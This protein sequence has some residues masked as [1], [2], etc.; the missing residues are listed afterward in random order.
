MRSKLARNTFRRSGYV[1]TEPV[2][3]TDYVIAPWWSPTAPIYFYINPSTGLDTNLGWGTTMAAAAASPLKTY[4]EFMLRL[5]PNGQGRSYKCGLAAG[6][7][8]KKDGIT[9]DDF[10]YKGF[11]G[12]KFAC[13]NGSNGV[14]DANDKVDQNGTSIGAFTVLAYAGNVVTVSGGLT[15]GTALVGKKIRWD[16]NVTAALRTMSYMIL[17]VLSATQFTIA[18]VTTVPVVG[19][20]FLITQPSALFK[21]LDGFAHNDLSV[22][23]TGTLR[24]LQIGGIRFQNTANTRFFLNAGDSMNFCEFDNSC[25]IYAKNGR[26]INTSTTKVDEFGANVST[27]LGNRFAALATVVNF[28]GFLDMQAFIGGCNVF[29]MEGGQFGRGSYF[30]A[31][32]LFEGGGVG[33]SA[34]GT[35]LGST[36]FSFAPSVSVGGLRLKSVVTEVAFFKIQNAVNAISIEGTGTRATLNNISDGG[37]NVNGINLSLTNNSIVTLGANVNLV[38]ATSEITGPGGDAKFAQLSY[39][40]FKDTSNKVL[41]GTVGDESDQ[42]VKCTANGAIDLGDLVRVTAAG[43]VTK[44]QADTAAN[45]SDV[46]GCAQNAAINGANCMVITKGMGLMRFAASPTVPPINAYLSEATAGLA[47]M[48]APA[49]AATNQKLLVGKVI[50][51]IAAQP[52]AVTAINVDYSPILA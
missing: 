6:T 43:V 18:A 52:L 2:D 37:G 46:L 7:Y 11:S 45:A 23:N 47:Q 32:S 10:V 12:Y 21:N 50:R 5:P 8:R 22:A 24:G 39:I 36:G 33:E 3:D 31:T 40:G 41:L 38:P 28:S 48:A 25:L 13:I 14:N 29:S 17:E 16:G 19:D 42:G 51:P 27:R 35:L 44:A 1:S 26:G 20:S 49:T 9:Q 4:E 15:T 30:G 34:Q